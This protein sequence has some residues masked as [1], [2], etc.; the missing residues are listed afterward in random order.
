MKAYYLIKNGSSD[1][2]FELRE[3]ET[4]KP[5]AGE[6]L[7]KSQG[8]GLNFAD[9]MA[10]LGIYKE[11]PP[12]PTVVGYENVGH[13]VAVGEGVTSVKEGDRVL[14]FTRFGGY[15]DHVITPVLAVA[16][17]PEEWS[18]GIA[19][20]LA[21]QYIT[22]YFA[23]EEAVKLHR[24]DHVLVHAAAGGVGTA[25]VQFLKAKGCIIFGTASASKHEY[26]KSLG[27]DYPI[28]YRDNDYALEIEKLGFKGKIDA[29]YNP[30]GGDYVKRD[31]QLLNS[32]G[33]VV[34]FGASKLTEAKGNIIKMLKLVFGFGFWSPIK[35]VSQSKSIIGVNMLHIGDNKPALLSQCL[36]QVVAKAAN[37]DIQPTVGKEFEHSELA[38]AHD[39][40]ASRKSIGKIA[41]NW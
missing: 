17:I 28:D 7:V 24:G 22:A 3:T 16:K 4:P 6:V 2:A 10:R 11:C 23:I 5:N 27:V 25:L 29:T 40:L 34:L 18:V 32:G 39:F 15:A 20:A 14:A 38:A 31:Y 13:V 35:F 1:Q 8:F 33:R 41:I 19:T 9:V 37:G 26:L 30:I 21:T 12:L 36:Q